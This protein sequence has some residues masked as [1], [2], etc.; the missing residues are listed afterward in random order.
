[1]EPWPLVIA[2]SVCR[3][4]NQAMEN[5]HEPDVEYANGQA[6]FEIDTPGG[7]M[8]VTVTEVPREVQD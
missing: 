6:V 2:R 1:M 7:R 4:M 3:S 5:A 8:Q